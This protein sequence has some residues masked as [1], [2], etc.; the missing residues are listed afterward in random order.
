M[1][2]HLVTLLVKLGVVA[3]LASIL[4]RSNAVQRMLLREARTLNQR[5]LLALWFGVIFPGR[6]G[7]L[8]N[9]PTTPWICLKA[10]CSPE[11]WGVRQRMLAAF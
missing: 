2:R 6:G 4:V 7:A 9:P 5:L 8:L 3:S 1:E 11:F 10:A